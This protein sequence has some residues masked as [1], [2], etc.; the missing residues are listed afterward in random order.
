M[1]QK[2]RRIGMVLCVLALMATSA[3]AAS[4]ATV[5]MLEAHYRGITLVV[6]GKP[7]VPKD[8]VGN[9]IEPFIV[10]GTTYLPVRAI[11][12]AFGKNVE[13][14]N[15]TST[16]YVGPRPGVKAGLKDV[17]PFQKSTWVAVLDGT[18]SI[19]NF[20][21]AG[22]E[23]SIGLRYQL[24]YGEGS[25]YAMWNL[26]GNYQNITLTMGHVD[27]TYNGSATIYFTL[28]NATTP[29]VSYELQP[30]AIPQ[31]VTVPLNGAKSL[32]ISMVQTGN[33]LAGAAYGLYDIQ[34]S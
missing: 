27:G 32:N 12:Q 8:E 14:D 21:V 17:P 1:N 20:T 18:W 2:R 33:P 5:R 3:V 11:G 4:T 25:N 9:L 34:F 15:A 24:G 19:N 31:T 16:V 28:D 6:D 23:Q 29:A 10:D 26:N 13:W 22:V 30:D 7:V